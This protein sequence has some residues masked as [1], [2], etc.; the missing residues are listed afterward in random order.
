[1]G[2]RD[3]LMHAIPEI[4][5]GVRGAENGTVQIFQR[6]TTNWATIYPDFEGSSSSI[7]APATF[8]SLDANGA[9]V[10]F[11][12]QLVDVLVYTS[13]GALLKQFG[14]GSSAPDIEVRSTSFTGHAYVS[15]AAAPG[16]PTT[17][18]AVLD[19]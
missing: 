5:A 2:E 9:R 19:A 1:M 3:P 8:L 17:L 16:N 12:N 6:A 4:I 18:Q 11:V 10:A 14:A 7:P 13:T 15:G